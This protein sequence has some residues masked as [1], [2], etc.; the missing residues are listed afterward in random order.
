MDFLTEELERMANNIAQYAGP[1][2]A[3]N[4]PLDDISGLAAHQQELRTRPAC[5]VKSRKGGDANISYLVK[6]AGPLSSTAQIQAAAGLSAAPTIIPG[7]NDDG[8]PAA[9]CQLSQDAAHR[10]EAWLSEA[11]IP[12]RDRPTFV[13]LS[14]A[15]KELSPT[16][17]YPT[18]GI[19]T[20]LPQHRQGSTTTFFH[21]LQDE[22]PVWY[23]FYGTL[24]DPDKLIGLLGLSDENRPVLQRASVQHGHIR[25]W[26]GKYNALVDGTETVHG[27][28]YCVRTK[29]H[30]DAL[31]AYETEKYEVVR[32]RITMDKSKEEF[33]GCTF[34]FVD[35]SCLD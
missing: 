32:C 21:P 1:E 5:P 9:F 7:T 3:S 19:D 26:A 31:R 8:E 33:W 4:I 11:G 34:R 17:R 16:S 14:Q 24:A 18:L 29:E 13:R 27:W 28:A 35:E 25:T 12:D 15:A 30:E 22:W 20:T 6:L 23:F 10:I 2:E